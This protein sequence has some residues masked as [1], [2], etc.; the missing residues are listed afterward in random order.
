MRSLSLTAFLLTSLF[1]PSLAGAQT[2]GMAEGQVGIMI[3]SAANI[4]IAQVPPIPAEKTPSRG[5]ATTAPQPEQ[6][7]GTQVPSQIIREQGVITETGEPA[8]MIVTMY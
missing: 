1:I 2:S 5:N 3:V 8:E 4:G 6:V 7:S